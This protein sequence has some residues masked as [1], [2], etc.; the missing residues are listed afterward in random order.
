M[1]EE[2]NKLKIKKN[3]R[4]DV[5]LPHTIYES[6]GVLFNVVLDIVFRNG[7]ITL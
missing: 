1:N 3:Q 6:D 7:Y 2:H 5:S 4:F